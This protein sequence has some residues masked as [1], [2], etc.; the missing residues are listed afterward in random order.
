MTTMEPES[1]WVVHLV[2]EAEGPASLARFLA[3]YRQHPAG[4]DHRLILLRKG[5]RQDVAWEAW[6]GLLT[7]IHHT[8]VPTDDAGLDLGAYRRFL[9]QAQ[10]RTVLFLNSHS[11]PLVDG[12]LDL[13]ARH[14]GPDRLV[15]ASGSW[16]CRLRCTGPGGTPVA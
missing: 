2:R 10:G 5:F 15:G 6:H 9:P 16:N 14:S 11:E 8:V 12:W 3:A 4:I 1:L 13:I 7:G